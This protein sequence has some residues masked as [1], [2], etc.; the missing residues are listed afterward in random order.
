[1]LLTR[2]IDDVAADLKKESQD[3]IYVRRLLPGIIDE[4]SFWRVI[5]EM[6]VI[7]LHRRGYLIVKQ[8]KV[9]KDIKPYE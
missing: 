2:E 4:D 3:R 7:V 6:L 8:E 5:V 9:A 1:M